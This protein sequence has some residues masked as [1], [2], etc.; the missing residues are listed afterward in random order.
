MSL[1]MFGALGGKPGGAASEF[2]S[3]LQMV[4]EGE[5]FAAEREKGPAGAAQKNNEDRLPNGAAKINGPG[6]IGPAAA[7]PKEKPKPK[8]KNIWEEDTVEDGVEDM[9]DGRIQP[10]FEIKYQQDITSQDMF[11]GID[12]KDPSTMCCE[13]MVVVVEMPGSN[14]KEINLDVTET[15]I[16]VTSPQFKLCHPLPR[17]VNHKAGNAKWDSDK[18]VLSVTLPTLVYGSDDGFIDR[19]YLEAYE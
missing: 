19:Q 14:L 17:P 9:D 16:L 15:R 6:N 10:M 18:H 8:S 5:K 7:A 1:D 2:S 4:E 13:K 12:G 3:L 11:L